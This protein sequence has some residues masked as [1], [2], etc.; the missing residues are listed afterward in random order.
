ML[1]MIFLFFLEPSNFQ[2]LLKAT[3]ALEVLHI[4][5]PEELQN[6][7]L[8]N[9]ATIT[10][11]N[12]GNV[13]ITLIGVVAALLLIIA[14]Y[15]LSGFLRRGL[16]KLPISKSNVFIFDR[17]LHYVLLTAGV[18]LALTAI[19]LEPASIFWVLGAL[20]VGIGF[21]L[22]TIVN[23]FASSL[24]ILF[25]R[26][27]KLQD[28]IQ[29]ESGEWGQVTDI[30]VQ[31]TIIRTSEGVEIVVPNSELIS[32]KFKNWTMHD[33]YKRYNIPFSVAYGTNKEALEEI[34]VDAALKVPSTISNHPT[35]DGP[36]VYMKALGESALD[37]ELVVWV[38]MY[39]TKGAH[40]SVTSNYLWEI[41]SALRKNNIKIPCPQREITMRA[42]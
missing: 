3:Q 21:G 7:T 10:L 23:N 24:I 18:L 37:F 4:P 34:L 16:S 27:I 15:I 39:H 14:A 41:E 1:Y 11:F 35:L 31:N 9:L 28:Y 2:K 19:G 36:R 32:N 5:I 22:Q 29:L 17:L 38:N 26:S 40:G 30:S 12:I 6:Q 33:P 42:S 20:S 25:S 13:P 8:K